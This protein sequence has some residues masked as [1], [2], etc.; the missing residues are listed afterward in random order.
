MEE[1]RKIL[2]GMWAEGH[3]EFHDEAPPRARA[4]ALLITTNIPSLVS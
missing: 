4:F 3:I 2:F 1:L